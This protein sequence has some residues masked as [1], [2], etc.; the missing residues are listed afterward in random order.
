MPVVG[1]LT[2]W[3]E[4]ERRWEGTDQAD[5][6]AARTA[7]LEVIDAWMTYQALSGSARTDAILVADIDGTLVAANAAA[8]TL[9]DCPATELVGRTVRDITAPGDTEAVGALWRGFLERGTMSGSYRLRRGS[10]MLTVTFDAR[11]HH[12]IPG[13]FSSRLRPTG[14]EGDSR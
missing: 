4:A 2:A 9:I 13:Y 3:R 12:P 6:A 1:A 11:A 10:A 14:P 7:A 5:I 8:G